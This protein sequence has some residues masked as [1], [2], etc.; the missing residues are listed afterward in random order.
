MSMNRRGFLV[1]SAALAVTAC[2]TASSKPV[3]TIAITM[4]DFNLGFDIRLD[5]LARNQAILDAFAAHNH[6]AAGFVTGQFI[7]SDVGRAVV[8]SWASAGHML[9][10][11]TYTHMN[12]SDEPV[13]IIKADI[14]KNHAAMKGYAGYQPYFRFPYLAEGG[15]MDKVNDY[16]AFMDA[17][18]F[19]NAPVTIDSIDWYTT[20]R[21]E[22]RLKSD[23]NTDTSSYGDYYVKAVLEIA[24]YKHDL[25][26][27]LGYPDMPHSL[28]MHHNIL[29]GLYL[30]DVMDAL[31]A[32]GWQ[33]IDAETMLTHPVYNLRPN[34]PNRGRSVLSVLAQERGVADQGFPKAYHGFGKDTMDALGL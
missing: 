24:Q 2:R 27:R 19:K 33:F 13:D 11:H 10:N 3:K 20:D 4:D 28:L 9:G 26:V 14:L 15:T 1:G 25:A 8:Q 7:E 17:N 16:R 31:V 21:L 29:N 32:D 6:K 23:P 18:G 22:K 30:R 5:S 34:I 12:S